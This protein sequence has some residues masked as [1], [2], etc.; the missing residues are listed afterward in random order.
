MER[1]GDRGRDGGIERGR[2][3]RREGG[4]EVSTF[5]TLYYDYVI[6]VLFQSVW[7]SYWYQGSWGYACCH[8][9]IKGSYCTGEAGRRAMK[10]CMC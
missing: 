8:S 7:G 9:L 1:E 3:G 10:V 2:E 6:F 5:L 4:R